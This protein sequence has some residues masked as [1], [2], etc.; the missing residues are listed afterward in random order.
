MAIYHLSVKSGSP[1]MAGPHATYIQREG[2]YA[3]KD[4]LRATESGNMPGWSAHDPNVFWSNADDYERA[5]G[6][7]YRELEISLPREMSLSQ[8]VDLVREFTAN[9]LGSRHAYSWAIHAPDAADGESQPHVH[10]MFSERRVDGIDRNPEDYFRRYNPKYPEQGGAQKDRYFNSQKFVWEIRAEWAAT[11][12]EHLER[13][14]L[15]ARIDHR[16]HRNR[17]I[18]L[19]PQLKRG[20]AGHAEDRLVLQ[21]VTLE[22]RERAARNGERLALRPEV[23]IETLTEHQSMFSRRDLQNLIFRNSDS[24]E[25]FQSLFQKVL[26]SP[27]LVALDRGKGEP[28]WFTSKA[29]F[30]TEKALVATAGGLA[31]RSQTRLVPTSIQHQVADGRSFNAGQSAAFQALTGSAA[32]AVVNGAAGSGKSYVLASVR[33]AYERAGFVVVGAT[34]QGKTAEDLERDAGIR[35]STLHSFLGRL[36]RGE[37]RLDDRT[38]VIV[39]EAGLVGSAQYGHLLKRVDEARATL[40]LVGDAYQLHAVAAGDAFRAISQ[41][42]ASAGSSAALTEI[43]RQRHDWQRQ[44]SVALSQHR[45]GEGLEAYRSRGFITEFANRE[46]ARAGLLAQWDADR[47][48][49]PEATQIIVTHTNRERNA[50]NDSVRAIRRTGGELGTDSMIQTATGRVDLAPGDRLVFLRNDD[51]LAVK[52]GTLGTVTSIKGHELMVQVDGRT[53]PIRVDTKAYRDVDLGYALTVHKSQGVTV[54]RA[55]LMAT[56]TL[57]ARLSYVSLTRH[58]EAVHVVHSREHFADYADLSLRLSRVAKKAFTADL[59]VLNFDRSA[60]TGQREKLAE[61]REK[62]APHVPPNATAREVFLAKLEAMTSVKIDSEIYRLKQSKGMQ[63]PEHHPD[64]V[65]A[66]AKYQ[67][68]EHQRSNLQ[69]SIGWAANEAKEYREKYGLLNGLHRFKL[70]RDSKLTELERIQ[71][72]GR[73]GIEELEKPL[74]AERANVA[75]VFERVK[76]EIAKLR[77]ITEEWIRA[78]EQIQTRK[79]G[80][81]KLRSALDNAVSARREARAGFRDGDAAWR[82]LPDRVRGLIDQLAKA[83]DHEREVLVKAQNVEELKKLQIEQ[84]KSRSRGLDMGR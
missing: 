2:K 12:N 82:A 29:L 39:D 13:M 63:R 49:H 56:D 61:R 28:E 11:A 26:Q 48:A 73:K 62:Q 78:A 51:D 8:Q 35:S 46:Q 6:R 21:Q 70:L 25:Q 40:R 75:V 58:R 19:E 45:I 24:S 60:E 27:E 54:D 44:A 1:G 57:E 81:E 64:M 50:L 20:I 17:D 38:V 23:A 59:G 69:A 36:D 71:A 55:Y 65:Q 83:P 14:G 3:D 15:E 33:E 74:A 5:N 72:E 7:T 42:A 80:E 30:E 4:D 68:I 76:A 77:P 43:V 16:S 67:G 34:L 9:T 32:L 52:N 41:Q 18:E 31:S 47:K 22:N 37:A 66:V 79:E 84:L 53:K 10:L